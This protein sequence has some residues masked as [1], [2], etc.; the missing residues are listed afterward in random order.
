MSVP[1]ITPLSPS[2]EETDLSDLVRRVHVQRERITLTRNGEPE[3]VLVPADDLEGLEMTL[4]ILGDS[5]AAAR[6]SRSLAALGRGERR[7]NVATVRAGLARAVSERLPDAVAAELIEFC[8]TT[9]ALNPH[10]I[11]KPLFGP[12]AGCRGARHGTYRIVY[13][14]DEKT[15]TVEVLDIGQRAGIHRGPLRYRSRFAAA[16]TAGCVSSGSRLTASPP[17]RWC[18][19]GRWAN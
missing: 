2:E 19:P 3:A 16:S 11:G 14:V 17:A 15:R 18:F 1:A 8:N 10:Q 4:E 9:L 5:A 6:I 13:R 12:L 7:A